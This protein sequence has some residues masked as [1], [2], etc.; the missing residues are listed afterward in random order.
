[1]G[2][3]PDDIIERV[4]DRVDMVGTVGRFVT[5]KRSGRNYK[6]LCPF[7]DE[8]T[9]S[10]HVNPERQSFHC[11]GC[12]AGGNAFTFL[13]E[14]EN[15]TF[16]EAIRVLAREYG[17]EV[18]ESGG[19]DRGATEHIF[20]AL[21]A[22]QEFYIQGL[23]KP[24]N[25]GAAYLDRRGI[26]AATIEKFGIGFVP[27]AWDS[28]VNLLRGKKISAEIGAKAGLLAERSSG[29]HYDRLRGRV[30]FPIRDVRGRVIAFGGRAI[31][32]DQ[33]PKYLNTPESPVFRKRE[34]FFGFPAALE[35][36]RRSERAVVVEGYFDQIALHR[37]GIEGSVATC[38]TSLT[39]EH[40]RGLR[41]RTQ[42]VVLMFDGDEAGQKAIERSLE[43]LLPEGLRAS[44]ALLP[45]GD[46]P[47]TYLAREGAV[48][49]QKLVDEAPS[50]IDLAIRR[51]VARGCKAP[52]EKADAVASVAPLLALVQ[53]AVE[54]TDYCVRLAFAVGTEE[55]HVQ[56]AVRAAA[57]GEDAREAVPVAPQRNSQ[58]DRVLYQMARSLTEHPHLGE[59]ISRDEFVAL[60]PVDPL[61]EV[62]ATLIDAAGEQCSVA[63]QELADRLEGEARTLLHALIASDEGVDE[64]VA[65]RTIDDTVR[66]LQR[67]RRKEQQKELTRRLRE[68]SS[69]ALDLL[70]EKERLR[71]AESD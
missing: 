18:P 16:P 61:A 52:W 56:A 22:A 9:P 25:P 30:T 34:A 31:G 8:K 67:R 50:A 29:G 58:H 53:S 6:G 23:Q 2:R 27:D 57:R 40:G 63:V 37:A 47:D 24:G 42:H 46:D 15:L 64:E 14:M 38:G 36:I 41:R 11:F 21:E 51:A 70:R 5:L 45:P 1:M 13:M 3:I 35:P 66:W 19:G 71:R 65:V 48:A 7:H 69:D 28:V 59:R 39:V 68:P 4:R 49:L 54:R 33:Q 62:I 26:D 43:V 12:Q 10:F 44:A 32:D 20:E 17:I 60:V 55:R